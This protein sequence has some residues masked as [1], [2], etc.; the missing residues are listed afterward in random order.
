MSDVRTQSLTHLQ[1]DDGSAAGLSSLPPVMIQSIGALLVPTAFRAAACTCK[2]FQNALAYTAPGFKSAREDGEISLFEW[3]ACNVRHLVG[4]LHD[5]CMR[6]DMRQ[7]VFKAWAR[8][9][10]QAAT[11]SGETS[12]KPTTEGFVLCDAPGGGKT[13]SVLAAVARTMPAPVVYPHDPQ[14]PG[15]PVSERQL[16]RTVFIFAPKVI[17]PQWATQIAKHFDAGTSGLRLWCDDKQ[18]HLY[19][20]KEVHPLASRADDEYGGVFM[21]QRPSAKLPPIRRLAT[22]DILVM[23]KEMLSLRS[24]GTGAPKNDCVL[25]AL[26]WHTR[27]VV[28]DESHNL[29]GNGSISNQLLNVEGFAGIPKVLISGTPGTTPRRLYDS[30]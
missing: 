8:R 16:R 20:D 2:G 12:R 10:F 18:V 1:E 6:G 28:V 29:N 22:F 26:K 13:V 4:L 30:A 5:G 7:S 21:E 3:Q 25:Q 15:A 19:D 23:P 9:G 14:Y 11:A 24:N 17:V 27:L